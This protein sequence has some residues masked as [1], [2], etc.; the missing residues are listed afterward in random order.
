LIRVI[1]LRS[2]DASGN[3]AFVLEVSF[4]LLL[5]LLLRTRKKS[6]HAASLQETPPS[7]PE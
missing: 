5:L 3:A 1:L 4:P 6:L 7:S 2:V